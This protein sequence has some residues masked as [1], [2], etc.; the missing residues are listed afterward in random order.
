MIASSLVTTPPDVCH[1]FLVE[2]L[3]GDSCTACYN[4]KPIIIIIIRNVNR[5]SL[6]GSCPVK[7]RS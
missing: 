7:S 6:P 1:N 5:R 4:K 2:D 3:F